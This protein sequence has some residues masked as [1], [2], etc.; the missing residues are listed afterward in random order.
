MNARWIVGVDG[1]DE[2]VD[3]LRWATHHASPRHVEVTAVSAFHVPAIMSMMVAK[4]GFGVDELGLQA[5]AG[6]DLDTAIER[7]GGNVTALVVEGQASHVLVDTANEADLLVVG[8]RGSGDLRS[9]RLGSVSRYCATHAQVPVVVV[10]APWS[11]GPNDRIVVGFD[12][13]ENAAAA[14]RWALEFASPSA[15]ITVVSAVE[16]APWLGEALTRE[17]FPDEVAEQE[18]QMAA[19]VDELDPERRT[20]RSVVL[21]A[22]R[23]ALSDAAKGADL[24]VVGAR[25]RGVIAAGFLGSV[26]T[27]LLQDAA[28]PVVIV[29]HG[30]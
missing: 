28:A 4:R 5:T 9:H 13:S 3:A 18:Q 1:S 11:P 25:G 8:Q 23:V 29:P 10:P 21:D 15:S 22:P 27:W 24:V 7:V 2:A 26:S 14:V 30:D 17:R 16:V 6:H 12:G 20:T 19:A